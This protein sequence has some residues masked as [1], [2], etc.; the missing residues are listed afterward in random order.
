MGHHFKLTNQEFND[1]ANLFYIL[2]TK[3]EQVV[4]QSHQ[5]LSRVLTAQ[6]RKLS[7]VHHP[8]KGGNAERFKE[9]N[10]TYKELN[11][12]IEPLK[13]G[14]PCSN[15]C[16]T[17]REFYYRKKLFEKLNVIEKEAVGKNY[18]ELRLILKNKNLSFEKN[19]EN[20]S[21]L[22]SQISKILQ[23][24]SLDIFRKGKEIEGLKQELNQYRVKPG[25]QLFE[26]IVPLSKSE[27]LIEEDKKSLALKF[28]ERQNFIQTHIQAYSALPLC[29]LATVTIGYYFSWWI[30]AFNIITNK[31]SRLLMND[32]IEKYNNEEIST[33]EFISKINYIVLGSKLLLIYPL[34]AFSVYLLTT[35]FIANGLT[36]GVGI[37][38]SLFTLAILIEALAPVFSKGCEIYTEK[39]TRDLLEED[40]KDKVQKETDLLKR[41]DPRKLLMPI[42]M[43]LVRKCFAEVVGECTERNF[44]EANT[45]VS[46]A[47]VEQLPKAIRFT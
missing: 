38:G 24:P 18:A 31:A 47:K 12:Y 9:I 8:D 36:I 16:L 46:D 44:D 3:A 43:P 11:A 10:E 21:K 19:L 17:A 37:L 4:G 23:S 41:Y 22:I 13:S 34:A 39:H 32:Y 1:N 35:N 14:N 45:N 40:P 29:L 5:E 2:E 6:Y 30:I 42:I 33:D 7:R 28:I 27:N 20:Y 25:I 15:G 26:Y